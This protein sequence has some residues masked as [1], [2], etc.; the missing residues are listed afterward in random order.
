MD[1]KLQALFRYLDK[2][3]PTDGFTER[4]EKRVR[5][6]TR[7]ADWRRQYMTLYERDQRNLA[8]GREEGRAEEVKI[9]RQKQTHIIS[10]A[11]K[12]GRSISEIAEFL[13]ITEDEV[14]RFCSENEISL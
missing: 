6:I 1:H 14:R 5:A 10:Q 8:K 4:L 3:V 7:D 2:R 13:C 9:A 11:L 12:R